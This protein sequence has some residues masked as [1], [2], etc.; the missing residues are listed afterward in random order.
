MLGLASPDALDRQQPLSEMGMDS[1]MAIELRNLLRGSV[2]APLPATLLFDYPTVQALSDH[3]AGV[4]GL[5]DTGPA[6]DR[7]V[8]AE[9]EDLVGMVESMSEEEID[10]IF[11]DELKGGSH[12]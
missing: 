9:P 7:D 3:L 11:E 5:D 8:E 2:G 4:L 12:Y 6:S 1:L 10:R